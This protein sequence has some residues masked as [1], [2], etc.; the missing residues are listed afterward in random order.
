[1]NEWMKAAISSCNEL[2]DD[3]TT[4]FPAR[5][6][7]SVTQISTNT[8]KAKSTHMWDPQCT[9]I[10]LPFFCFPLEIG[11]IKMQCDSKTRQNFCSTQ[12]MGS[13]HLIFFCRLL[14][15]LK[16]LIRETKE[17]VW[18][19][20]WFVQ[21]VK[22]LIPYI[23]KF[24]GLRLITFSEIEPL[25]KVVIFKMKLTPRQ[26]LILQPEC[27]WCLYITERR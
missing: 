11:I 6:W 10:P 5:W 3:R 24:L 2:N 17:F 9:L 18:N 13:F 15:E 4:S 21:V 20:L 8:P 19:L 1:M 14:Q 7:W 23:V 22:T 25:F 12:T 16:L 27:N 26:L